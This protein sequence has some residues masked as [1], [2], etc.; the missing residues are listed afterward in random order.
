MRFPILTVCFVFF[1][2]AI[3]GAAITTSGDFAD[4]SPTP[5]LN[6]TAPITFT[7]TTNG[8]VQRLIFD[9]WV[10]DD[11]TAT[12]LTVATPT[13]LSYQ[14]N[15]GA[16]QF[17][18]VVG[19]LD[20]QH[21]PSGA[22]SA[23]DGYLSFFPISVTAGQTLTI[24]AATIPFSADA[25]FNQPPSSLAGDA[26]LTNGSGTAISAPVSAPEPSSAFLGVLGFLAFLRRRAV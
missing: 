5:T 13:A 9:E 4:G 23:N 12:T 22:L 6:I 17:T 7:I 14:I 25:A 26:R 18:T 3:G 1:V 10:T 15:G 8:T 16:T 19:L 2:P 21:T 20:N 11:G 24:L